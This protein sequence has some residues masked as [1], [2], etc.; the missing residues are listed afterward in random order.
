MDFKSINN[1][2]IQGNK[3]RITEPVILFS[4]QV[5]IIER[6]QVTANEIGRPDLIADT[7]Y[8]SGDFAEIILKYNNIS[9]PFSINE[10]DI[11]DIPDKG[12]AFKAWTTINKIGESEDELNAVRDQFI[13]SKRLTVQDKGRLEYLKRKAALKSNGSK[14][15]L[16]PNILK[17]G[18]K[19]IDID[20]DIITI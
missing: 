8:G 7:I 14:Q 1:K 16:P 17:Q 9:N 13:N 11:L 3:L 5:R 15:I 2:K 18:D 6:F 10:G 12:S 19:N 20:G 4:D